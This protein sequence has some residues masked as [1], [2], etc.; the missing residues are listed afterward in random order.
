MMAGK[1]AEAEGYL[2]KSIK[3]DPESPVFV[4][5]LAMVYVSPQANRRSDA[6][7]LL[8]ESMSKFPPLELTLA[9]IL[10]EGKDAAEKD[11]AEK[12][13][14][15]ILEVEPNNVVASNNLADLLAQRHSDDPAKLTE[16]RALAERAAASNDPIALDTLGWV[17]HLQGDNEAA[18]VSLGKAAHLDPN[19]PVIIYHYAATLADSGKK[20][21]AKKMLKLLL[22]KFK[23]FPE[24][25]AAEALLK[26]L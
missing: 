12:I 11:E 5:R 24:R 19:T 6:I 3:L 7:K 23:T 17:Q 9:Q 22:G 2:Q 26:T 13:Y 18:L 4:M 1:P 10:G 15:K 21:E 20:D 25:K 8:R 14:R 16:A